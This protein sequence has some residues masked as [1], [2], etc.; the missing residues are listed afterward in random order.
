MKIG[1]PA[2]CFGE[3]LEPEVRACVL[4]AADA[5]GQGA[6]VEEFAPADHAVCGAGLLYDRRRGG[7]FQPLTVRRG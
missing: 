2:D 5:A 3:G 7:E 6:Q 1:L 4:A